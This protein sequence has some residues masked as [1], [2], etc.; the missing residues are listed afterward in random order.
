MHD[1]PH[2]SRTN[3]RLPTHAHLCE[4]SRQRRRRLPRRARPSMG[5]FRP[6]ARAAVASGV[7]CGRGRWATRLV[8]IR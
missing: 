8:R 3:A 6:R 5:T 7:L 4:L 1:A 2:L